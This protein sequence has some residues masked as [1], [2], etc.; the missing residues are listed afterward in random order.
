M[1]G[2]TVSKYKFFSFFGLYTFSIMS[3]SITFI[4]MK[5]VEIQFIL[6]HSK[7]ISTFTFPKEFER[8]KIIN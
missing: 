7:L 5:T 3:I 1:S 2:K 4:I 8:V 6:T